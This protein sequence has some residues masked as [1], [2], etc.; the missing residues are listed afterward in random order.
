VDIP[1]YDAT[2]PFNGHPFIYWQ[3]CKQKEKQLGLESAEHST[4]SLIFRI[5]I[6]N[7]D[8]RKGQPH[9][10][11]ELKH[12]FTKWSASL[13]Y[14]YVDVDMNRLSETV[15]GF[16]KM[17]VTPKI[18]T[19][20]YIADCLY[21]LRFDVLP[22]DDAIPGYYADYEYS[23][24]VFS[25][26]YATQNQYRF[27]QYIS[28]EWESEFWQV[29]NASDI[30]EF[31]DDE[32]NWHDLINNAFSSLSPNK[33]YA[34][35]FQNFRIDA[36]V[37]IPLHNLRSNLRISPHLGMYFGFPLT[38]KYRF[39]AGASV[40]IPV[41]PKELAYYLPD[42]TLS[43]KADL[44]GT[45]GLWVSRSD[46][47]EN[48]WFIENRLGT[49]LGFLQTNIPKENP[50][51]E[52]DQSY[53]A[54]TIFLNVGTGIRKGPVGLSLNYFFVPYNAFKKRLKTDY[55]NQYLTVSTYYIF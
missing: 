13:Y 38:E 23:L 53:S 47:L 40:F 55:G 54:E 35:A 37:F 32:L 44:S 42:K 30:L 7:P 45:L 46:M 43:G 11:I 34:Q 12:D 16:G 18:H 51:N 24:P 27:Y 50:K 17:D 48:D 4:D 20:N 1:I 9:G 2:H 33:D 3:F 49:G 19:W 29:T 10:L 22:T 36:G 28:P 39:D 8:R 6:T 25:F 26:E 5:W 31:L 15:T 52:N 21:R 41:K 14:L